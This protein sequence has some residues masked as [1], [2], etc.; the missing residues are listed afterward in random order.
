RIELVALHTR[1]QQQLVVYLAELRDLALNHPLDRL[2]QLALDVG[3]ALCERPLPG[4]LRD[5]S[6][7]AQVAYQVGHEQRAAFGLSVDQRRQFRRE[8]MPGEFQVQVFGDLG[9]TQEFERQL[10]ARAS[11]LE[12]RLYLQE[13]MLLNQQIRWPV[14]DHNQHVQ[15]IELPGEKAEHVNGGDVRPMQIVEEEHQRPEAR[16]LL[17]KGA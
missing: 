1:R 9:L 15:R 14:S 4:R 6:P 8:T 17:Q 3:Q 11:C 7:V 2:G 13:R 16:D 5:R 10:S 12:I